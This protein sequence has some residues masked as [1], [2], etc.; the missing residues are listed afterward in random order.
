MPISIR[1]NFNTTDHLPVES[2]QYVRWAADSVGPR[3]E[4]QPQNHGCGNYKGSMTSK[5]TM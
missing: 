1:V 2:K 5:A 4:F 3:F